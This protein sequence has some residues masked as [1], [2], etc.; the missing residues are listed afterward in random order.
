M[1]A[2]VGLMHVLIPNTP[3]LIKNQIEREKLI[4]EK[5]QWEIQSKNNNSSEIIARPKPMF[6][7]NVI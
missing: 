1:F 4:W 3:K 5:I 7:E 6:L 2:L